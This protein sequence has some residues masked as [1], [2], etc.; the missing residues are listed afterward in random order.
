MPRLR[1]APADLVRRSR[2]LLAGRSPATA[3]QLPPT[4]AQV[5]ATLC[6]NLAT[7][8][9]LNLP[10][11]CHWQCRGQ[12]S[13]IGPSPCALVIHSDHQHAFFA[14]VAVCQYATI[15]PPLCHHAREDGPTHQCRW[16]PFF[17][18]EYAFRTGHRRLLPA[19]RIH[20]ILFAV[21]NRTF[22][23]YQDLL[24]ALPPKAC[25][26]REL[27]ETWILCMAAK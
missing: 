17:H 14:A 25:A 22:D 12:L 2:G 24:S 26:V 15:M 11:H 23:P 19:N 16:F 5:C 4:P 27:S 1:P 20:L 21:Q 13:H 7:C 9:C 8:S 18:A 6:L 10:S 3:H